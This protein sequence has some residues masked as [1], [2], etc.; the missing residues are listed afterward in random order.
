MFVF[1]LKSASIKL[2]NGIIVDFYN[3]KFGSTMRK[4]LLITSILTI[5]ILKR[6]IFAQSLVIN[7]V[8]LLNTITLQDEDG[9]YPDWIEIKNISASSINLKGYG[10]SDDSIN[11]FRWV[12]SDMI[13][14]ANTYLIIYASGKNRNVA[15]FPLHTNFKLKSSGTEIFLTDSLGNRIDEVTTSSLNTDISYGRDP[16]ITSIWKYFNTPTPGW[17]NGTDGFLFVAQ[18]P[19]FNNKGGFYSSSVS[20]NL[21]TTSPQATI[22][23]SKDGSEPT[24]SSTT[25]TSTITID[26]NTVIRARTFGTNLLPSEIITHTYIINKSTIL[27][28]VSISTDPKNLW[29]NN[30]GIFV[31]GDSAD[32]VTPFKGANFWKD[33]EKPIHIEMYEPN[34]SLGFSIDAGTKVFGG[35]SRSYA[36]KSLKILPNDKYGIDNI[37]YQVFPERSEK[38]YKSIVLR[39]SGQDWEYTMLRDAFI[40]SLVTG[41]G[42][43]T[44][45][46]RPAV[47][48]INGAYWGIQNIREHLN[49]DYIKDHYNVD[50]TNLDLLK[51]DW[52]VIEGS[53][54][55]YIAMQ[56]F[57]K[58]NDLSIQANYD[59]AKSLIDI[60][61]YI[62]YI[63][64]EIYLDNTDWPGSNIEFWKAKTPGSKWRWLLYDTDYGFGLY[65]GRDG[66]NN[67]LAM[68][69]TANG[70]KWPNPDWSTF[71]L[72]NLFKSLEFRNEFINRFADFANSRFRA[73]SVN[74]SLTVF[75][76][77]IQQEIPK[78]LQRWGTGTVTEWNNRIDQMR[79]FA[80]NRISFVKSHINQKFGLSGNYSVNLNIGTIGSGR[81]KINSLK[82]DNYPWTGSYF[83]N[84]P[85]TLEALPYAGY[86]FVRWDGIQSSNNEII[87]IDANNNLNITAVFELDT[88][89]LSNDIIINEINYNSSPTF[90]TKDWVELYNKSNKSI[91]LSGWVIKDSDSNHTFILPD[92]ISINPGE[93]IVIAE[94]TSALKSL[95]PNVKNLIGNLSFGLSSTGE[96][97]KLFN[98]NIVLVDSVEYNDKFPWPTE[99]D[100]NGSSLEL[101]SPELSNIVPQNWQASVDNGS[102]GKSNDLTTGVDDNKSVNIPNTYKLEQNYPN[103]FNPVTNINFTVIDNNLT[104]LKIY[105]VL[106]K[107]VK[108]LVNE[109]LPKGFY[110]IQFNAIGLASGVYIYRL[111]SGNFI[112]SKKLILMK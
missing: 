52:E 42:I 58:N 41:L 29:D 36:Q 46:Y 4:Y 44:Q 79:T 20:L 25:Y 57:I 55:D 30:S 66:S 7:E 67:T 31:M 76:N 18:Q 53:D 48:Y 1:D 81:I 105:D 15:S 83:N 60:D 21:S 75:V 11:V 22:Y 102:P 24:I 70:P 96:V 101:K 92:G 35:Y 28:I 110:N 82:I 106:G 65:D 37:P 99:A 62:N 112:S 40:Q 39:N 108:T 54:A 89:L 71:L 34:G 91:D 77:R 5:L 88:D 63:T 14:P 107:E 47:L 94:D 23:Y 50:K 59:S 8:M 64:S 12:F 86:H 111:I 95:V 27:P 33:W 72:I 9:D 6:S 97:I 26:S 68:A 109:V 84:V 104:T 74:A 2:V 80:N 16:S 38:S 98:N 3:Q 87:T 45:E 85:I 43:G 90:N 17:A 93:Y 100:G 61:N 32:P 13:L 78:H 19:Q 10:L 49:E 69:T 51:L 73:D 103:P 56:N